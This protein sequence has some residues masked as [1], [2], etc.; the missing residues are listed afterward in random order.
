[1][2][3]WCICSELFL[4]ADQYTFGARGN[5]RELYVKFTWNILQ[6][7]CSLHWRNREL[8]SLPS[9]PR[10]HFPLFLSAV[11]QMTG[12]LLSV[13]FIIYIV[14]FLPQHS[15]VWNH[16]QPSFW[17]TEFEIMSV[18]SCFLFCCFF[19]GVCVVSWVALGFDSSTLQAG[20][21]V[22]CA[23]QTYREKPVRVSYSQDHPKW[24]QVMTETSV[25]WDR[26]K[27]KTLYSLLR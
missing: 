11:C 15:Q 25:Y 13:R 27:T 17:S 6:C 14:F 8:M 3:K 21:S 26:V 12:F 2:S 9:L 18:E 16:S 22:C 7:Q 10:I 5:T 4:T 19:F 20:D 1:M 23:G 24:D